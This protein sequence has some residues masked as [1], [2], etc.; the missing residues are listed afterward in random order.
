ML[1]PPPFKR[2]EGGG[3][4]DMHATLAACLACTLLVSGCASW[5]RIWNGKIVEEEAPGSVATDPQ[6]SPSEDVPLA[7]PPVPGD[8]GSSEPSEPSPEPPDESEGPTQPPVEQDVAPEAAFPCAEADF[9]DAVHAAQDFLSNLSRHH[10]SETLAGQING[11]YVY[12]ER[13]F[14]LGN[15]TLAYS[16]HGTQM[17]KV[18]V[19]SE[20]T[21]VG[22]ES[23]RGRD[24]APPGPAWRLIPEAS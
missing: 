6:T 19:A 22:Q 9:L 4:L 18:A 11:S 3:P 15:Q 17:G 1:P 5:D 8:S 20:Y 21:V 23:Y 12:E 14:D 24:D 10:V 2:G 13:L 16:S 7:S